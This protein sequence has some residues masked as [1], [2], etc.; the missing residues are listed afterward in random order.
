M[1]WITKPRTID[2]LFCLYG[3][4]RSHHSSQVSHGITGHPPRICQWQLSWRPRNFPCYLMQ[5]TVYNQE[6]TK[7]VPTLADGPMISCANLSDWWLGLGFLP[8][9]CQKYDKKPAMNTSLWKKWLEHKCSSYPGKQRTTE[10]RFFESLMSCS[11][12]T[13]NQLDGWLYF[14]MNLVRAVPCK[15][16]WGI[17]CVRV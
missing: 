9:L 11:K 16:V 14:M 8:I 3:G 10:Q 12:Y 15:G 2:A 13:H 7:K 17:D 5:A 4:P 6:L 1:K